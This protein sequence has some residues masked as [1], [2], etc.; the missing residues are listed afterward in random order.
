M[1]DRLQFYTISLRFGVVT[2]RSKVV[3]DNTD[4]RLADY[5]R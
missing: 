3:G 1:H 4:N 5:L 2:N